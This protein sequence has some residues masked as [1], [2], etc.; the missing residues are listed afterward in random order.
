MVVLR[1]LGDH[2]EENSQSHSKPSSR[3]KVATNQNSKSASVFSSTTIHAPLSRL[4]ERSVSQL[5]PGSLVP[6]V[7]DSPISSTDQDGTLTNVTD[8]SLQTNGPTKFDATNSADSE[9][10]EYLLLSQEGYQEHHS[11]V[12]QCKFSTSSGYLIASGDIEGV[13]KIWSAG[14]PGPPHTL[15]TFI[16]NSPVTS[17]EWMPNSDT[18]F[19]YGTTSGNVRVC[20]QLQRKTTCDIDVTSDQSMDYGHVQRQACSIQQISVSPSGST[21]AASISLDNKYSVQGSGPHDTNN[22]EGSLVLYDLRTSIRLREYEFGKSLLPASTMG[23][24]FET[25]ITSLTFNHNSQLLIT[26]GNDGK[27]RIFDLRKRG[28]C[29]SSWAVGSND[30]K[31]SSILTIHPSVDDTSIYTLSK[32]GYFS[33][34]SIVQTSQ[35]MFGALIEDPYFTSGKLF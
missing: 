26:G 30:S 25:V 3:G 22:H 2:V 32:D 14:P 4:A 34:W 17:L 24:N 10:L 33:T 21:L 23:S 35:K 11:E 12:T 15:T 28:D 7:T 9:H 18:N 27:I 19:I 8:L 29:I 31:H 20:D 16:S 13:I 6:N 1:A 5:T